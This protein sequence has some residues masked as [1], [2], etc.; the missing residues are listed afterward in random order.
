MPR[1]S[2]LIKAA[3]I[4][5]FL[6]S[7][8]SPILGGSLPDT[9]PLSTTWSNPVFVP[10]S[11]L[12]TNGALDSTGSQLV[13]VDWNSGSDNARN[14]MVST[15]AGV[16][17]VVAGNA[18]YSSS[19]VQDPPRDTLPVLSG[20]G[21]R[22]A[23]LGYKAEGDTSA[24]YLIDKTG[25]TWGVPYLLPE[26]IV[27]VDNDL[28]ISEDGNTVT[29]SNCP[30]L[31]G[32]MRVY[33][34]RWDGN[35]WA[36]PLNVSGIAGGAQPSIAADGGKI[37]YQN[38]SDVFYTERLADGTWSAP[39]NL[40]H[41]YFTDSSHYMYYP[42]ISPDGNAVFFWRYR[43]N[44]S[45]VTGKDLFAIRRIGGSWSRPAL[46]SGPTIVP[47]LD[48]ESRPAVNR[49]GTRVVFNRQIQAPYSGTRLEM[50][51]F[52]DGKWTAPAVLTEEYKADF[53]ALT[54]DG[55][56]TAFYH[57]TYGN[58]GM[59]VITF[60]G[61]PPEFN[62]DR[63]TQEISTTGGNILSIN[64]QTLTD[65]P[66]GTFTRNAQVAHTV[67][68]WGG[69]LPPTGILAY[70]GAGFDLSAVGASD[71]MPIPTESPFSISINYALQ[72]GPGIE[73]SLKL[74]NWQPASCQWLEVPSTL[75][76]GSKMVQTTAADRLGLYALL[77]DTNHVYL[78]LVLK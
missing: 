38:Y 1:N 36:A 73:S 74:Y 56:K 78:P 61:L 41:C 17:Q 31:F 18:F 35:A 49:T 64:D 9:P 63:V 39:L 42:R 45:T 13:T 32:T 10:D 71:G 66:A 44:G 26:G 33:V 58:A 59:A 50:T 57:A 77:G 51:E 22:I 24:I 76:V 47:T 72:S 8:G 21:Q 52:I 25:A 37:V 46:I 68:P 75:N 23:Y 12:F 54:A 43:L 27:C 3:F 34:S 19:F 28:D 5:I 7:Y 6:L 11:Y 55:Q 20:S 16:H 53:P 15:F 69:L 14:L 70:R 62:Y 48:K 60:F 30:T 65:F 40:T 4:G 2:L 67:N 29:Y